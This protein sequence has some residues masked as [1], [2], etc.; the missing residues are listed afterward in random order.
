MASAIIIGPN[1]PILLFWGDFLAAHFEGSHEKAHPRHPTSLPAGVG[2]SN[3]YMGQR[4]AQLAHM[5][6]LQRG[7]TDTSVDSLI[8]GLPSATIIDVCSEPS[9]TV[10]L[11]GESLSQAGR[12]MSPSFDG[13]DTVAMLT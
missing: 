13:A 7:G 4:H 3:P 8:P 12:H 6:H 2:Q 10:G 1:M 5:R 9:L 11:D